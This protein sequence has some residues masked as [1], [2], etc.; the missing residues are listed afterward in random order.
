M[1]HDPRPIAPMNPEGLDDIAKALLDEPSTHSPIS[2]SAVFSLEDL[3]GFWR[4]NRVSY[5][6]GIYQVE[7]SKT[8]I[9][10]GTQAQ[11]AQRRKEALTHD[12]F[13]TPDFPLFHGII[14]TLHQ[15]REGP[16]K[17]KIGAA[18]KYLSDLVNGKWLMTLTRIRYA[19]NGQDLVI[20]AYGQ[21]D[22]YETPSNF[23]GPDGFIAKP[24]TNAGAA[25]QA[26]LGTQQSLQEIN[27]VYRWFRNTDAYI[28]RINSIPKSVDERVARF[29]AGS[30]RA[31]LYCSEGPR[32]S[33]ASLGVRARKIG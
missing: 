11:H 3:T 9:P 2:Q 33:V 17:D 4:I 19:P 28:W 21:D 5:R 10:S 31:D 8:L 25:P 27:H 30:G 29:N 7:V 26:L 18:R 24:E 22:T 16:C 15:N 14:D 32:V 20:H 23:V 13:Y 12:S 6:N 1:I